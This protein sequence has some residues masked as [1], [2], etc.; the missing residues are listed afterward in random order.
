MR[1]TALQRRVSRP[2]RMPSMPTQDM[3]TQG[4]MTLGMAPDMAIMIQP[5]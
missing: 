2:R 4:M 3:P 5:I 1:I